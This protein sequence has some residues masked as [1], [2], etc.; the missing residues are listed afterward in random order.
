MQIKVIPLSCY[1]STLSELWSLTNYF[2]TSS[3]VKMMFVSIIVSMTTDFKHAVL[4][5]VLQKLFFFAK[6]V[7][8]L[9]KLKTHIQDEQRLLWR[10]C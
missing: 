4:Q 10:N 5:I 9:I 8:F 1:F 3:M 7:I 6:C 2:Q